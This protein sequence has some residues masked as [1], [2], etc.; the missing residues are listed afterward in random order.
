MCSLPTPGL[1]GIFSKKKE[2]E[3]DCSFLS[4]QHKHFTE[5]FFL[6]SCSWLCTMRYWT[7]WYIRISISICVTSIAGKRS[8]ITRDCIFN[9]CHYKSIAESCRSSCLCS[10]PS[11]SY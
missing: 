3:Q 7:H 11:C 2:L 9:N 1:H 8:I 6:L 4:L 10:S 5:Q